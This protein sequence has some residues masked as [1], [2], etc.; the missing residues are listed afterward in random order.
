MPQLYFIRHAQASIGSENYDQ[1]SALGHQQSDVLGRW[2]KS[3]GIATG[4]VWRGSMQ[5]HQETLAGLH[6]HAALPAAAELPGLNEYDFKAVLAAY[7]A[8]FPDDEDMQQ[9]RWL[10]MLKSAIVCWARAE[11]SAPN[12]ETWAEFQ[13]RVGSALKT[14][15]R[16]ALAQQHDAVIISSAG[17]M[18]LIAQRA[19]GF[20]DAGLVSLN[21]ALKNTAICEYR[22]TQSGL[23][24]QSFNSLPHLSDTSHKTLHTRV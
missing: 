12:L 2:W 17:V 20:D 15:M 10:P 9:G 4:S 21:M 13:I 23:S 16:D 7:A 18:A 1:L 3:H 22:L 6:K 11:I 8:K 19:L 14:I 24:L 5:R